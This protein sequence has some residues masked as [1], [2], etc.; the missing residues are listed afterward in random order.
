[1]LEGW[2]EVWVI[3]VSETGDCGAAV[4]VIHGWGDESESIVRSSEA[5]V[6]SSA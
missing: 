1:M 4:E 3:D 6:A 2:R 5:W